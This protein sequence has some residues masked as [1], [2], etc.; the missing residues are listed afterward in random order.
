VRGERTVARP[1]LD[2]SQA[3]VTV[4]SLLLNLKPIVAAQK[5]RWAKTKEAGRESAGL[6]GDISP[7]NS[8]DQWGKQRRVVGGE[9]PRPPTTWEVGLPAS[10]VG[11]S[12]PLR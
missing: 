7:P 2:P 10:V 9:M 3:R 1:V 4:S 11:I 6:L 12:T 8:G 5:A